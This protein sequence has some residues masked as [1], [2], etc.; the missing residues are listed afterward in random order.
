VDDTAGLVVAFVKQVAVDVG[1]DG[2]ESV[3]MYSW[4]CVMLAPSSI[5]VEA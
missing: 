4:T 5:R 1:R 2:D 3:A